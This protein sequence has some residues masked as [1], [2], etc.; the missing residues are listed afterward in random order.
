VVIIDEF[1]DLE[2]YNDHSVEKAIRSE[3]QKRTHIG[4]IFS[5]SEQSDMLAMI[6]DPNRAFYKLGRTMELGPI[7]GRAYASFAL[8]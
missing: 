5:G 8:G 7:E 4:F 3:I 1:S 2:K 6:R